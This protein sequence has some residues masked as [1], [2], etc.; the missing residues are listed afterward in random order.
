MDSGRPGE[1][2]VNSAYAVPDGLTEPGSS[3]IVAE[4]TYG[5]TPLLDLRQI[6]SPGSFNIARTFY[7]RPRRSLTVAKTN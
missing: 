3:V 5:F 2:G 4:I 1:S 7:T 6:I